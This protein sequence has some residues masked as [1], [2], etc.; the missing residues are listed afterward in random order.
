MTIWPFNIAETVVLIAS[1][2]MI[3]LLV[4]SFRKSA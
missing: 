2:P 1:I 4:R 3:A